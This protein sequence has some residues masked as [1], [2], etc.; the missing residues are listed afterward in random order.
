[1]MIAVGMAASFDFA[2]PVGTPPSAMVFA[3][4]Y[5]KIGTMFKGG[6]VMSI[7]GIIIVSLFG[8]YSANYFIP[9]PL[10]QH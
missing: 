4:G 10:V 9:W 2:L 1:M 6:A 3:S 8:Y 5:V 7:I